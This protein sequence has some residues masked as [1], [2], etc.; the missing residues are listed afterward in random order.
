MSA[1]DSAYNPYQ[2]WALTFGDLAQSQFATNLKKNPSDYAQLA[3]SHVDTMVNE[4]YNRKRTTF[5][6][7]HIDLARYMDMEHNSDFYKARSGDVDRLTDAI[8]A[9]NNRIQQELA[10]DK[11][12]SRR[13]FEINDWYNY[14]KLETLFFL[15]LFFM[16]SL[17]MAIVIF[18]QKNGTLTTQLASLI[19]LIVVGGLIITGVYRW[20]YTNTW[21]DGRLWHR[22]VFPKEEA[23]PEAS[24]CGKD[25]EVTVVLGNKCTADLTDK[26]SGMM[27]EMA[28]FQEGGV[29]PQPF[30]KC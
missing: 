16:A 2:S 7:A 8:G 12:I 21:R 22:R 4:S 14:N 24:T 13:Q 17:V 28:A 1:A 18:L 20:K 11:D 9:N 6:K 29:R 30:L 3:S 26:V 10:R 5:Q 25:T 27:D 19:T 15:Q 23:P